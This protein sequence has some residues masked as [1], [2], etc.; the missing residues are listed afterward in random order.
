VKRERI[1]QK[2]KAKKAKSKNS[3]KPLPN[4][5]ELILTKEVYVSLP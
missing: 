2:A 4:A 3:K 5:A 1:R